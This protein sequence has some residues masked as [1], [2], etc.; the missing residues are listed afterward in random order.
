[1]LYEAKPGWQRGWFAQHQRLIEALAAQKKRSPLAG[2]GSEITFTLV[3]QGTGERL[4]I[5]RD[6]DSVYD[7]DEMDAGTNPADPQSYFRIESVLLGGPA[8]GEFLLSFTAVSNH[9]TPCSPATVST[10]VR[11]PAGLTLSRIPRIGS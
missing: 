3:A 10:V 4:G 9:T 1:V 7:G 2:A 5:D 11:G 8:N 6:S